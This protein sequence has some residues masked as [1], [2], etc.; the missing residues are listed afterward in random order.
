MWRLCK[1]V[2]KE[3]CIVNEAHPARTLVV[4][5]ATLVCQERG[6]NWRGAPV[7]NISK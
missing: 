4:D 2:S 1:S 5:T 7:M 6:L 3:R